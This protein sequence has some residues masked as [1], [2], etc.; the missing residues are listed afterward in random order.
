MSELTDTLAAPRVTTRDPA[1][2]QRLLTA[3]FAR[4]LG[5]GSAPRLSA[6]ASP[7]KAGMSSETLLFELHW[8]EHGSERSGHFV[9]RL[10]PPADAFPLFP[11][12][13]FDLQVE[14]MRLVGRHSTVPVPRVPWQERS[15]EALGVPF[16]V[17][18]RIDGE[19]VPDNPPY[20]FGGWLAEASAARQRQ[21]EQELIEAIAGIH[22]IGADRAETAFLHIDQPGATAL[23][24]HFARERALYEWGRNGMRFALVER[25]F[26]WLE[27]H[28]PAHEGEPVVS[29]GDARPANAL[30]RDARIVAVLDWELAMLGP[31]EMDV[32]YLI[33]FHQYFR[34]IAQVMA[35]I[36]PMAEFLRRDAVVAA[37]EALTGARLGD[38]DWYITY[39]LLQQCVI[40][41]RVSQRRILFGEMERPQNSDEYLYGRRLAERVLAGDRAIW[42]P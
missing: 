17:M 26:D 3:W 41:I 28:W 1:E 10:P 22:G 24:R 35:A 18:E 16:F 33:F 19:M 2:L 25:L 31:R 4:T 9:A 21:V 8:N 7:G 20:V 37:Y 30:W 36:D 11:R 34:H 39:A 32:G 13:D 15:S 29:W 12:Y 14:A 6:L 38:I 42:L 23:R 5:P 27:A 40:D